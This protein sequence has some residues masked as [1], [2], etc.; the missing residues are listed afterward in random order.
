MW[1]RVPVAPRANQHLVLEK[2]GWKPNDL[3]SESGSLWSKNN[4]SEMQ[5]KEIRK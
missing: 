1:V 4:T 2:K 3:I 5:K